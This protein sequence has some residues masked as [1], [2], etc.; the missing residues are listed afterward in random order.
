MSSEEEL[1]PGYAEELVFH[2]EY[3]G[4]WHD[5]AEVLTGSRWLCVEN[6]GKGGSGETR[7]EVPTIVQVGEGGGWT[8]VGTMEVRSN[9]WI[10]DAF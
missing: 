10:L 6:G 9:G 1:G 7:K 3:T 2:S 5:L 8:R 4:E